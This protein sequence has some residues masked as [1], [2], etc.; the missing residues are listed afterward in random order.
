VSIV[1][2]TFSRPGLTVGPELR[3]ELKRKKMLFIMMPNM[4]LPDS[5]WAR[6]KS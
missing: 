2:L 1:L 5:M 6:D 3:L 4:S